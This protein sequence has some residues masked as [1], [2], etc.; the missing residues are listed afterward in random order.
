MSEVTDRRESTHG[1]Y[2]RTASIS[3]QLKNVLQSNA[4]EKWVELTNRQRESLEMICVKIA[5]IMSGDHYEKD[6]WLD[7]A[8]YAELAVKE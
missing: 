7:I 8:G 3:Q 2:R 5:R 6:H 1:S 4:H